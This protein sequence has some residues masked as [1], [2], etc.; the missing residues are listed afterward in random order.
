MSKVL[1]NDCI[2]SIF[3]GGFYKPFACALNGT[4]TLETE[5]IETSITGSGI[6]RTG[7]P[8]KHS[9]GFTADGVVSLEETN[10]LDLAEL[11]ALQINLTKI[12]IQFTRTSL[13]GQFY[14]NTG[15]AYFVNTS[16]T[17]NFNGLD[18]F[19]FTL[20]GTGILNQL[21]VPSPINPPGQVHRYPPIGVSLNMA[22]G[23]TSFSTAIL[24][25]K[26]V[27]SIVKDG[28]GSAIIITTGT[29]SGKQAK[30]TSG[31]GIGTVA[32]QQP[33]EP[34]EEAYVLYQDI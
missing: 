28:L 20:K 18:T 24:N 30:Y 33:F 34:N 14:I 22:G 31:G 19:N 12:F 5:D 3:S 25:G 23:E 7:Q 16:D 6:W 27:L 4:L 29:P 10:K 9:W 2:F 26:D 1:G 15:Y 11:Q 21:F 17:G 8:I 13:T 32:F